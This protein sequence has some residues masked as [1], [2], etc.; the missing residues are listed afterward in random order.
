MKDAWY[1]E[2]IKGDHVRSYE[3]EKETIR[4]MRVM[5]NIVGRPQRHERMRD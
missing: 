4:Y 5:W 1:S 3:I 2:L